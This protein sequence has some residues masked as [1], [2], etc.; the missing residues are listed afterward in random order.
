MP[1]K[2][3]EVDLD[4]RASGLSSALL[5]KRS[6]TE[7]ALVVSNGSVAA[8][9]NQTLQGIISIDADSFDLWSRMR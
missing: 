3:I 6:T 4:Q 5:G 7:I 2:N 1:F 9:H 8:P